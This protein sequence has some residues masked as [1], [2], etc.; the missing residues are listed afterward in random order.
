M[1]DEDGFEVPLGRR[2]VLAGLGVAGLGGIGTFASEDTGTVRASSFTNYPVGVLPGLTYHSSMVVDD[3]ESE[4]RGETN[5]TIYEL[6][7]TNAVQQ[8]NAQIITEE[9][10]NNPTCNEDAFESVEYQFTA[11][12]LVQARVRE[13]VDSTDGTVLRY[14]GTDPGG[15]LFESFDGALSVSIDDRQCGSASLQPHYTETARPS[16]A[17]QF[18]VPVSG[19]PETEGEM[20]SYYR[21]E[22]DGSDSQLESYLGSTQSALRVGRDA[23][24]VRS[25]LQALGDDFTPSDRLPMDVGS[26]VGVIGAAYQLFTDSS[27]RRVS[28]REYGLGGV[29]LDGDGNTGI[30]AVVDFTVRVP[31]SGEPVT[32]TVEFDQAINRTTEFGT[33]NNEQ[34]LRN[35]LDV[36]AFEITIPGNDDPAQ[37]DELAYPEFSLGDASN[38]SGDHQVEEWPIQPETLA[39]DVGES[40]SFESSDFYRL[41][42]WDAS[43]HQWYVDGEPATE[44]TTVE[45]AFDSGGHHTVQLAR[46]ANDQYGEWGESELDAT[47]THSLSFQAGDDPHLQ[48]TAEIRV[49]PDDVTDGDDVTLDASPSFVR[50]GDL[51]YD[52]T[53]ESYPAN[54]SYRID[55]T[56]ESVTPS[57]DAERVTLEGVDSTEMYRVELT[58]EHPP[59]GNTDVTS[60]FVSP[61]PVVDA[62]ISGLPSDVLAGEELTLS[63]TDSEPP[64]GNEIDSYDWNVLS[65]PADEFLALPEEELSVAG[66]EED[67][68]AFTPETDR[69]YSVA[70]TV[71]AGPYSGSANATVRPVPEIDAAFSGAPDTIDGGST[72]DLDATRSDSGAGPI[73]RY[74]WAVS[75]ARTR[76][77]LSDA[78][79]TAYD[80]AEVSVPTEG[81]YHYRIALTV[82]DAAG[83]TDTETRHVEATGETTVEPADVQIEDV[84]ASEPLVVGSAADVEV[85]VGNVGGS[86][87]DQ[88]VS[89]DVDGSRVASTDVEL[90]AGTTE[91]VSFE[92]EPT[93]DAVPEVEVSVSTGDASTSE[94]VA[95]ESGE[96]DRVELGDGTVVRDVNGDGYHGDVT[97]DGEVTHLDVVEFFGHQHRPA[98]E[99]P[100]VLDF[101]G[102]GQV[103]HGDVLALFERVGSA[104]LDAK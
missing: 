23:Y 24:S 14:E 88:S 97:G 48:P 53:V 22:I 13:D 26:T 42:S 78:A 37:L 55:P 79:P 56:E 83:N 93:S 38:R 63:A 43:D 87:A 21:T 67:S 15:P 84:T 102:N 5:R 31:A 20:E 75:R 59:T 70:L 19:L 32:A 98:W 3:L 96:S 45:T 47:V 28:G 103:G 82:E 50:G 76:P 65:M 80:G 101:N 77:D 10:A 39:P 71:E 89:L 69:I 62:T 44:D 92:Y 29:T 94:T 85:T 95:V 27:E 104:P 60:R 81:G 90:A 18:D 12:S 30:Q 40:V 25:D 68:I 9:D 1:T 91:T 7:V 58:V 46:V 17:S 64:T 74:D 61:T 52:W 99:R 73:E 54:R 2:S 66:P 11:C 34:L 41:N 35:V 4:G 36:A 100:E 72:L 57:A 49:D 16:D 51:S 33:T 8:T 86:E 6:D